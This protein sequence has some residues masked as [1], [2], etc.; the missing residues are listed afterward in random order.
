MHGPV[1]TYPAPV[2]GQLSFLTA[3]MRPAAV[4]DLEGFLLAGGQLVRLGGT[5]RLSV[6]VEPGWRVAAALAAC[7]D[8]GLQAAAAPA[9]GGISIRTPFSRVLAPVAQRWVR[10]AMKSVPPAFALDGARLRLWLVAAGQPDRPGYLLR[11]GARDD[12]V[13]EPAG[14]A[15]AAVGLPATFLGP[16][17]AGPGYRVVGRRRLARLR[18]YVGDPPDGAGADWPA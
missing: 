4:A 6:V 8:R 17:A 12:A 14:A 5:A 2:S 1:L 11:I 3:G 7:R 13:W 10:G 16:R 18:E 9:E 15:L